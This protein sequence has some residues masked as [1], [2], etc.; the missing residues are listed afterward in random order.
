MKVYNF[1]MLLSY[2]D[3]LKEKKAIAVVNAFLYS[4]YYPILAAVT[5]VLSNLF[6]LELPV[7]YLYALILAFCVLFTKDLLPA[8]PLTCCGYMT[9]SEKNNPA[10]HVYTSYFNTTAGRVQLFV[11]VGIVA[12]LLVTRFVFDLIKHP[13][14][15]KIPAL[16]FG[17]LAL[18]IAYL[19]GGLFSEYY[20]GKTVFFGL[21][22]IL[23]LSFFYFLFFY[24]IE[25]K[26]VPHGYFGIVFTSVAL[27]LVV[28][29]VGMY[30]D[31]ALW[32][33]DGTFIRGNLVTGWGLY[34]NVGGTI[35]MCLP[36]PFYLAV[37]EKN[38]WIYNLLGNVVLLGIILTQSRSSILVGGAI[39]AVC[40]LLVLLKTKGRA[41]ISHLIVYGAMLFAVLLCIVALRDRVVEIF[42][43]IVQIGFD[44]NG[45]FEIY[46]NGLKQF[47]ENPVFGNGF[48]ECTAW[49]LGTGHLGEDAFLPPR[50]HNTIVQ[51]LASCGI[52]SLLAYVFHRVQTGILIFRRRT[53]EKYFIGLCVL[54]LVMASLLDCHFFNF[55]PGLLYS[56]LLIMAE[57]STAEE[58]SAE[59]ED[60]TEKGTE[61]E[62]SIQ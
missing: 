27:G 7:Y 5:M 31:P 50:Y 26:E 9:F 22:Q 2:F 62:N 46:R 51:L 4:W 24:T 41:R 1:L 40:A 35:A 21:V 59:R 12:T 36:A 61:Q 29:V 10:H 3:K 23:S 28:E 60:R 19:L 16:A 47:L 54:A 14:R 53:T 38:G 58:G 55:G 45:R 43:S 15:R 6:G 18:G 42:Y 33:E 11:L 52:V 37:K 8:L 17:F 25:W 49:Q 39:Y 20:S 57:K 48:Y 13:E 44:D 32:A 56:C 34:N 30:F